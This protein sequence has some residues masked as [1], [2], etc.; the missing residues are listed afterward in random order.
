MCARR[1]SGRVMK[2]RMIALVAVGVAACGGVEQE[3]D[4]VEIDA[5]PT[6]VT[7]N[8]VVTWYGFNDNSCQVETQHDCNTIAFPKSDGFPVPHDIAA[9]GKGTFADPNTFATA[10]KDSGSPAELAPGTRIYVPSV[11]KYFVMEDQCFECGQEW[12][13]P[14]RG[15]PHTYH[16]VDLWMGPSYGSANGPLMACEDELTLGDTYHGTG[17]IIVNP[18]SN[19][20]VDTTPLFSGNRGTAH[21]YRAGQRGVGIRAARSRRRRS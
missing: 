15:K 21:T 8:G 14:K 1:V 11:R 5:A 6:A 9:A 17:T 10:A 20:P 3:P 13:T 18:P 2:T 7:R 12:F 19:L 4:T 16:H